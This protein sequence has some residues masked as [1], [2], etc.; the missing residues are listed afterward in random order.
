MQKLGIAHKYLNFYM[1][2][3]VKN[4]TYRNYVCIRGIYVDTF[5][6]HC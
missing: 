4:I 3:S 6:M 1:I 5:I 2:N